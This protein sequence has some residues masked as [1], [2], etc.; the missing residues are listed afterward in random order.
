MTLFINK[1]TSIVIPTCFYWNKDE[2][3]LDP[4]IV[5]LQSQKNGSQ[6]WKIMKNNVKFSFFVGD[7]T[8]AVYNQY[9]TGEIELVT[10][11]TIF[12]VPCWA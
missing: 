3:I 10:L 7:T 8:H 1:F 12:S 2:Y 6:E 9:W 4:T 11:N 5:N